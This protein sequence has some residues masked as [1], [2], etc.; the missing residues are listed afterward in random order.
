MG[1]KSNTWIVVIVI[2]L[3]VIFALFYFKIGSKSLN[4][5]KEPADISEGEDGQG[6]DITFYKKVNGQWEPVTIPD[7]FKVAGTAVVGA[8]VEHPPAPICTVTSDCPGNNPS[9]TCWQ[10][11]CVLTQIDGMD[12]TIRVSNGANFAFNDVY[13][14]TATP[15]GFR[16]ALPTGTANKKQLPANGQVS[17]T[18]SIMDFVDEGWVGTDQTFSVDVTGK[19]SYDGS[20]QTS[21][22]SVTLRF[23]ED[24]TGQFSVIIESGVPQ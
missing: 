22:D 6:M 18:S 4:E 17:W 21:S 3:I 5:H 23:S 2:A 15:T 10:G 9:V 16:S 20:T 14:S 13:I 24:P 1:K 8:I 19:S 7:W 11:K 12:I